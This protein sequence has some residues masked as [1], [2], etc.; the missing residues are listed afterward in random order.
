MTNFWG[1]SAWGFLNLITVLQV[2]HALKPS[3]H[4]LEASSIPVSALGGGILRGHEYLVVLQIY[5]PKKEKT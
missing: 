5:F 1:F 4:S 3:L 2:V